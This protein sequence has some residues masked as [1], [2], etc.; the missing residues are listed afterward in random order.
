[1]ANGR[2]LRTGSKELAEELENRGYDWILE[3]EAEVAVS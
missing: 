3:A 1:M 2:I